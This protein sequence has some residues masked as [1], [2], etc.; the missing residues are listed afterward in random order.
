MHSHCEHLHHHDHHEHINRRLSQCSHNHNR[1]STEFIDN[2]HKHSCGNHS[3][4]MDS[5]GHQPSIEDTP[6]FNK[7]SNFLEKEKTRC[8]YSNNHHTTRFP[9]TV[10]R[11]N[12]APKVSKV[13]ELNDMKVEENELS[14]KS[15]VIKG[16]YGNSSKNIATPKSMVII[17]P[18]CLLEFQRF[19]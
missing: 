11:S 13:L 8:N 5:N 16:N 12:F 3:R 19:Q 10:Q 14:F 4:L 9:N 17:I 6:N 1:N 7:G 15:S 18:R 2:F